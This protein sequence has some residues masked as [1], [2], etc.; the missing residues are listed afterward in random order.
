[1]AEV[2]DR[3]GEFGFKLYEQD[4]PRPANPAEW[5]ASLVARANLEV[6]DGAA[7]VVAGPVWYLSDGEVQ[8]LVAGPLPVGAVRCSK[9]GLPL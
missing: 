1:L 8:R 6:T 3:L 2:K 4:D 5:L 9:D 7:D